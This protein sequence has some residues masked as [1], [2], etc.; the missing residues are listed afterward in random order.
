MPEYEDFEQSDIDAPFVRWP[1]P[2][3]LQAWWAEIMSGAT[4]RRV[5]EAAVPRRPLGPRLRSA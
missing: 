4:A 1:E 2:S 3:P 5:T